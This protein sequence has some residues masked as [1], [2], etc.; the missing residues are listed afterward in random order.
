MKKF[1][2]N[3]VVMNIVLYRPQEQKN[4]GKKNGRES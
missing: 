2:E 4:G 3:I 1:A